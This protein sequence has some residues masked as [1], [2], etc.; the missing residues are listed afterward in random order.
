MMCM[1]SKYELLTPPECREPSICVQVQNV[2]FFVLNVL[3]EAIFRSISWISCVRLK[4]GA[5]FMNYAR[6][7]GG[8]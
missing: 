8:V 4:H 6:G 5:K 2:P 7:G 3:S 1:L